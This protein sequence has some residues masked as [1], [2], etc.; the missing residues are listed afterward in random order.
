MVTIYSK[1]AEKINDGNHSDINDNNNN[2]NLLLTLSS[3]CLSLFFL[4]IVIAINSLL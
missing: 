1:N 3:F 4:W 2:N